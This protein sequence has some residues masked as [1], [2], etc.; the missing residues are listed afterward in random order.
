[1]GQ[2]YPAPSGIG[3][4]SVAWLAQKPP[5]VE[6]SGIANQVGILRGNLSPKAKIAISDHICAK[7]PLTIN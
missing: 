7:S 6:R 4:Y 1:L 2:D 5:L 3:I